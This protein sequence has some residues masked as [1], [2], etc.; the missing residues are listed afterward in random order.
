[1]RT[2]GRAS[3]GR[4]F[5]GQISSDPY[6]L[7]G[8]VVRKGDALYRVGHVVS[9]TQYFQTFFKDSFPDPRRHVR[10]YALSGP[11]AGSMVYVPLDTFLSS[12]LLA[13]NA[14][15]PLPP[16]P[17]IKQTAIDDFYSSVRQ[18][19]NL[20]EGALTQA[21]LGNT[22]TA[23]RNL[24]MVNAGAAAFLDEATFR[25]YE[26]EDWGVFTPSDRAQALLRIVNP[27]AGAITDA[28]NAVRE[29]RSSILA[30]INFVK[31]VGKRT[32]VAM[33]D[34]NSEKWQQAIGIYKS[35]LSSIGA[36]GD[37][38]AKLEAIDD[39]EARALA[40][41]VKKGLSD[42]N[43]QAS[44]IRNKVINLGVPAGDFDR[45]VQAYMGELSVAML[46]VLFIVI[47]IVI[48]IVLTEIGNIRNYGTLFP[49]AEEMARAQRA[50]ERQ[51]TKEEQEAEEKKRQAAYEAAQNAI[52]KNTDALKKIQSAFPDMKLEDQIKK[53]QEQSE[54]LEKEA[55]EASSAIT[56]YLIAAAIGL[57]L[58]GIVV[59]AR[60]DKGKG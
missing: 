10:L 56:P 55:G 43:Y 23:E 37:F 33:S 54:V 18:G 5:L 20:A 28:R 12:F 51:L 45:Q 32:A 29:S 31:E 42:L 11:E 49:S 40:A 4:S 8:Q 46:V 14:E 50:I 27:L 48:Q 24:N 3:R 44:V 59:F 38:A 25:L 58:A 16:V 60:M 47:P 39:P 34:L 35:L 57:V 17:K 19:L 21:N 36:M 6:D 30:A 13:G 52:Q 53:A 41:R 22:Q 2:L 1:M 15:I 9:N 26:L 7:L